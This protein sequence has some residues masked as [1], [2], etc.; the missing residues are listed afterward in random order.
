MSS[1]LKEAVEQL[2]AEVLKEVGWLSTGIS[3][4]PEKEDA[5]IRVA[6]TLTTQV[7][8][9][10]SNELD[11]LSDDLSGY[12]GPEPSTVS[13]DL[14]YLAYLVRKIGEEDSNFPERGIWSEGDLEEVRSQLSGMVPAAMAMIPKWIMSI[15]KQMKLL[16]SKGAN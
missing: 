7:K 12:D 4:E 6:K 8:V 3:L 1:S 13:H 10:I 11:E 16:P 9:A 15:F 5:D 14:S 2:V